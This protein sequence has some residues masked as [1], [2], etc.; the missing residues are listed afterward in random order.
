MAYLQ[1]FYNV[2]MNS[3]QNL[4]LWHKIKTNSCGPVLE[5][6]RLVLVKN[7]VSPVEVCTPLP[8]LGDLR[9]LTYKV[10]IYRT[11]T[12]VK[13]YYH[14]VQDFS[15]DSRRA[16]YIFAKLLWF[17]FSI[18]KDRAVCKRWP[19]MIGIPGAAPRN[20]LNSF[21]QAGPCLGKILI[22]IPELILHTPRKEIIS[23]GKAKDWTRFSAFWSPRVISPKTG[24]NSLVNWWKMVGSIY[25]QHCLGPL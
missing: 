13:H 19:T 4:H 20:H 16:M 18:L 3:T 22:L 8:K 23:W 10:K 25:S 1:C 11:M 7:A 12:T 15:K 2:K 21:A 5:F 17:G 24:Y 6:W 9:H 14:L